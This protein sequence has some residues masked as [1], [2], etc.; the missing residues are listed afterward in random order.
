MSN[1]RP[2][3]QLNPWAKE[4]FK[5]KF[6]DEDIR[7]H[8]FHLYEAFETDASNFTSMLM[9]LLRKADDINMRKLSMV[10]PYEAYMVKGWKDGDIELLEF[11]A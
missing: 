11:G 1:G 5:N 3:Y 7:I 2:T 8:L 4:D 6:G 10:Y 9:R